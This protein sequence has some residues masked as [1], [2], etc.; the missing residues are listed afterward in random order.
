VDDRPVIRDEDP[1]YG[2]FFDDAWKEWDEMA[3]QYRQLHA[4]MNTLMPVFRARISGR[5]ATGKKTWPR[6]AIP[7]KTIDPVQVCVVSVEELEHRQTN[8]TSSRQGAEG[9]HAKRWNQMSQC[10]SVVEEHGRYVDDNLARIDEL[11]GFVREE[12]AKLAQRIHTEE[13]FQWEFDQHKS[14]LEKRIKDEQERAAEESRLAAENKWTSDVARCTAYIKGM[15][16]IDG[17]GT[18][19]IWLSRAALSAHKI[20][21]G[22]FQA[23]MIECGLEVPEDQVNAKLSGTVNGS[24]LPKSDDKDNECAVCMD[25]PKNQVLTPCGHVCVCLECARTLLN[26]QCPVCRDDVRGYNKVF[27]C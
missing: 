17:M 2:K 19:E 14:I 27:I 1:D 16:A 12:S 21:D 5:D 15:L 6:Y 23:A 13:T 9:G 20:D 8:C 10:L 3:K 7:E 18:T 22:A 11:W 24:A 25:G 26:K 4:R